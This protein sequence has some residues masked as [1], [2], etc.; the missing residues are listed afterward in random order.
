MATVSTPTPAWEPPLVPGTDV[1]VKVRYDGRWA[2]GFEIADAHDGQY[3][4][5]RRIDGALLPVPF[6]A[7]DLRAR[8]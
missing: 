6:Q 8:H 5:R 3:Q 1:E 7:D 4:L 2:A